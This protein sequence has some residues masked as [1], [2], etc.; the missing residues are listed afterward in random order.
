[1]EILCNPVRLYGSTRWNGCLTSLLNFDLIIDVF[2]LI[3]FQLYK[4]M[5]VEFDVS[6]KQ[7][8]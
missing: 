2:L 6:K 7:G 5:N 4:D 3:F 1:M 8:Y